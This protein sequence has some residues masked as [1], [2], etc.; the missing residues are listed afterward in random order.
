[1]QPSV[2]NVLT[3][4]RYCEGRDLAAQ[5]DDSETAEAGLFQT[6]YNLR[7]ASPRL[8]ELFLIYAAR[9]DFADVFKT[10][11]NCKEKD[12]KNWGQGE[13]G[14]FQDLTKKC[15]AFAVE[16]AAVGLR[17]GRKHWGPINNRD[18]ELRKD[19]D[20]LFQ[21][22]QDYIDAEGIDSI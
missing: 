10:G 17:N 4:D 14:A 16:Y 22:A 11:V 12:W 6:S 20:T 5:N 15:P 2:P 9:T 3:T 19:S 1:M 7:H 21:K 13:G 18:A 8:A